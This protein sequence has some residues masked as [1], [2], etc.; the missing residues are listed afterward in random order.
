[1]IRKTLSSMKS[2]VKRQVLDLMCRQMMAVST[3]GRA[4]FGV[5]ELKLIREA[6]IDGHKENCGL[7]G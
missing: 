3:G 6:L 2:G 1:M 4:P 5:E 7:D